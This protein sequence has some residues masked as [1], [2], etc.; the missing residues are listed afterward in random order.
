MYLNKS[1]NKNIYAESSDCADSYGALFKSIPDT[2]R[3][4]MRG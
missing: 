3:M 2:L 4:D 1:L